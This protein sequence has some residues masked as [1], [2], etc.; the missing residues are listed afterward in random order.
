M[1]GLNNTDSCEPVFKSLKLLT[2]PSLYIFEVAIFV[3]TNLHLFTLMD[4]IRKRPGTVRS[5]YKNLMFTGRHKT[6]LLRKSILSMGPVIYNKIPPTI[7]DQS[8]SIFKK[9]LTSLLINKCYYS[10]QD[11]LTDKSI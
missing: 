11:F 8:L 9:R 4:N 3:R 7:K 2:F 10:I 5:Q 1:T 6:A